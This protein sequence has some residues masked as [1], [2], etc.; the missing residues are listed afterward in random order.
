M[1]TKLTLVFLTAILTFTQAQARIGETEAQIEARY[2]KP[3]EISDKDKLFK[4][5]LYHFGG[6]EVFVF[7]SRSTGLSELE[8]FNKASGEK[9]SDNEIAL[10]MQANAAGKTWKLVEDADFTKKQWW[11]SDE[12]VAAVSR[13]SEKTVTLYSKA[14]AV[15]LN[16]HK[17]ESEA[18]NLK[19]L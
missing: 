17:A 13:P 4:T 9:F 8:E 14:M 18:S 1:K 16:N 5:A 7:I 19:G 2:G 6:M 3:A 10:I 12:S 15:C 11:L